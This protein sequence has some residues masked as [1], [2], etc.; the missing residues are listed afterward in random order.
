MQEKN[1]ILVIDQEYSVG[2][3]ILDLVRIR[4]RNVRAVCSND[5]VQIENIDRRTVMPNIY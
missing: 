3:I 2:N 1:T 4:Y 5:T